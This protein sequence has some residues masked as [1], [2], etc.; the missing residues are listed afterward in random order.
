[1]K[2]KLAVSIIP[3]LML[4]LVGCASVETPSPQ[5]DHPQRAN[6]AP[7]REDVNND[8]LLVQ[9]RTSVYEAEVLSL[10]PER[11]FMAPKTGIEGSDEMAIYYTP[12]KVKLTG[13]GKLSGSEQY[14]GLLTDSGLEYNLQKLTPGTKLVVFLVADPAPRSDGLAETAPSWIGIL[15]D[16]GNLTSLSAHD[17]VNLVF[18]NIKATLGL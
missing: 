8:N 15:D 10:V 2:R 5:T 1:M 11:H 7:Y 14:L 4:G 17:S 9:P 12:V 13:S 6:L 16:G 18:D 3:I